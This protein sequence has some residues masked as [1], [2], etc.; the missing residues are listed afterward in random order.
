[1]LYKR[2]SR[3]NRE[4][5]W[6]VL[7]YRKWEDFYDDWLRLLGHVIADAVLTINSLTSCSALFWFNEEWVSIAQID[8]FC[9]YFV[10]REV[11]RQKSE[12]D[13]LSVIITSSLEEFNI[14]A[15]VMIKYRCFQVHLITQVKHTTDH[16]AERSRVIRSFRE[17]FSGRRRVHSFSYD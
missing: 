2:A 9:G 6:K 7:F 1:M 16:H 17:S 12:D 3:F 5:M 14:V 11:I 4:H 15:V 10:L 13:Y 8:L